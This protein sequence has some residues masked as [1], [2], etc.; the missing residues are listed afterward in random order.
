MFLPRFYP[1]EEFFSVIASKKYRKYLQVPKNSVPLQPQN[2]SDI[3]LG[4]GVMV[5]LQILVLS[6]LV[7]IQVAQRK[8]G[9][10]SERIASLFFLGYLLGRTE[11]IY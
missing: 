5:T 9:K 11:K 6:F 4:Y 10:L 3:S 1:L 8:Q 2:Q 7:R